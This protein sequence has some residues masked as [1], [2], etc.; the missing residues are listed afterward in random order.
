MQNYKKY[1]IQTNNLAKNDKIQRNNLSEFDKIQRNNALEGLS[2]V[3]SDA[4]EVPRRT[5]GRPG[6]VEPGAAR[7]ELVGVLAR[8]QELHQLPEP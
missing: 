5:E 6:D 1:I 7:E 2:L 8:L 3:V 4:D